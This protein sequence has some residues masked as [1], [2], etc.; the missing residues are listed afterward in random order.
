MTYT[1][2]VGKFAK[3]PAPFTSSISYS[4]Q[5]INTQVVI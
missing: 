4:F 3:L 5:F 1:K 2:P